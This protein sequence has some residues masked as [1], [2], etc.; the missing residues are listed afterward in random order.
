MHSFRKMRL[1]IVIMMPCNFFLLFLFQLP[2]KKVQTHIAR[3]VFYTLQ[4]VWI[5]N[6]PSWHVYFQRRGRLLEKLA[7]T[8]YGE[9]SVSGRNHPVDGEYDIPVGDEATRETRSSFQ[10][11]LSAG[12]PVG[13]AETTSGVSVCV[14]ALDTR[15]SISRLACLFTD[16][17]KF[18]NDHA[19]GGENDD[20]I[21]RWL[22][23]RCTVTPILRTFSSLNWLASSLITAGR[24]FRAVARDHRLVDAGFPRTM[25][26]KSSDRC[27]GGKQ[28]RVSRNL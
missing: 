23:T 11:R 19:K 20:T 12:Q 13:Y 9:A 3:C 27:R 1:T 17:Q 6:Q 2:F 4:K 22:V 28:K 5:W 10:D 18:R 8:F 16:E 26:E 14:C 7:W 21:S 24:S 25:R 15:N